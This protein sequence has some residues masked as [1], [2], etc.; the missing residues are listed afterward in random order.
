MDFAP[1]FDRSR[2]LLLEGAL[3]ERLKREYRLRFDGD[4]VMAGLVTR[5]EG[6]AALRALWREY[7]GIAR[8][9]G[10]PFLATTPTRRASRDRIARSRYGE[11]VLRDNLSFLRGVLTEGGGPAY[12]GALL[13]CHGDAYTGEGA[14]RTEEAHAVHSWEAERFVAAG[15]DFLYAALLPTLP[16]ALGIAQ[17]M[18][19]TA[20]PYLV[21]F[22]IRADGRLIDGTT[23]DEA[24]AR[25]DGQ[26]AAPPVCYLTNCVHPSIVAQALSQPCNRTPRVRERFLGIQANTSPLPYE[27]LDGAA[28]LHASEP[29][30]LAHDMLRLRDQFGFKLFGG[31][32]GTD[33]RHLEAVAS[34]L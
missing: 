34:A 18:A 15:A 33:G 28:E 20:L 16:E 17:A 10:L 19:D 21:S 5:I 25:I 11:S 22:T 30:A 14:L 24:V 13:G 3:G 1:C 8:A 7:H 32:C 29:E 9:H 6:R 26:I 27:E 23:I 4:V 2:A 12:A 31:C